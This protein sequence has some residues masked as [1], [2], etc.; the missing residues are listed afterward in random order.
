M[1][2]HIRCDFCGEEMGRFEEWVI[3]DVAGLKH[4]WKGDYHAGC[5]Q[6]I[7]EAIRMAQEFEGP[8]A[9]IRVDSSQGIAAKRRKHKK[10][11]EDGASDG[12]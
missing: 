7:E 11:D 1:S 10:A 4:D 5:W 9:A 2:R 8:L 12:R 3:V 6:R